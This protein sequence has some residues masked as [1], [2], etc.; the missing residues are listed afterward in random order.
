VDFEFYEGDVLNQTLLE[1]VGDQQ[2]P[3]PPVDL[4]FID[5]LHTF[6]QLTAELEAFARNTNLYIILHDMESFGKHDEFI[7]DTVTSVSYQRKLKRLAEQEQPLVGG[8]KH[9][10]AVS[11]LST[12]DMDWSKE[13]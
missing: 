2:G 10:Q 3:F 1:Q 4:L 6:E 8:F 11:I 5:T 13:V 9:V 12:L 7:H